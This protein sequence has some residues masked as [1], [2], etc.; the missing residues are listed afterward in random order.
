[1]NNIL[2][3]LLNALDDDYGVP[4]SAYKATKTLLSSLF[5]AVAASYLSNVVKATEGRYYLAEGVDIG[6]LWS[7]LLAMRRTP[8]PTSKSREI[9]NNAHWFYVY[10]MTN[11]EFVNLEELREPEDA[12][13]ISKEY[14]Q[15]HPNNHIAIIMTELR[16]FVSARSVK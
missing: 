1:M 6:Q 7:D 14:L 3:D 11:R 9:L 2:L 8:H 16:S 5:G 12:Q 13:A 10:D 4:E 15:Q